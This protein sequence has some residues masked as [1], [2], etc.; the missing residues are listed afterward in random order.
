MNTRRV[1]AGMTCALLVGAALPASAGSM[2]LNGFKHHVLPVLVTVN[3][4]GDVTNMSPAY[5][6]RPEMKRLV[7]TTLDQMITGPAVWKD[8]PI[9]SQMIVKLALDAK[10]EEGGKY[11]VRWV[12]AGNQPV[13]Y[14]PSWH[15]N[16]IDGHRLA[17]DRSSGPRRVIGGFRRGPP[18]RNR[19]HVRYSN[20]ASRSPQTPASRATSHRAPAHA[21]RSSAPVKRGR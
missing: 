20:N 6:L 16:H 7:R 17:L 15:W 21:G 12:Y 3:S 2:S 10:P 11:S 5:E 4:K 9:A 1:F 19:P 13:P 8:K 18:L 14:D